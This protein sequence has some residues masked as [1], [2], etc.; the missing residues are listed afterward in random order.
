MFG[1]GKKEKKEKKNKTVRSDGL[2]MNSRLPYSLLDW[3]YSWDK[4]NYDKLNNQYKHDAIARRVVAKPA[5]D[6]TR[7][8][9]RLVIADDPDKQETYQ[10]ALDKLRL[11]DVLT[12]QLIYQ[13]LHGDGYINVGVKEIN[14]GSS[15]LRKPLIPENVKDVAFVHAFGQNHIEQYQYN[16]DPTSDNYKKE[17]SI[18]IRPT[19]AGYK[20]NEQ[21]MQVPNPVNS[22]PIILDKSRYFHITLDKFEDDATGT[23]II[24]RCS[25]QLKAMNIALESTGKMLREFTFKVINSDELANEN[26]EDFER[27]LRRLTQAMNTEAIA[28]LHKDDELAKVATPVNGYDTLLNFVWQELSAACNIPKSVLTGEQAGSLAGA[29]QDVVNY[30]DTV[31]S[32]QESLLKPEIEYIV[33]L[34]MYADDIGDGQEDPDSLDWHIEFNPLWSPDDKTQSETFNNNANAASTLVSS[35]IYDPDEAK[36]ILNGMSNNAIQG[37]QNVTKNDSSDKLTPEQVKQYLDD[38]KKATHGQKT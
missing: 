12:Q 29:S 15:D 35:A 32:M 5:E 7:N 17:Q 13:R 31:K 14:N 37:M 36:Q 28:V 1:I 3:Q 24:T 19:Q 18:T 23:S 20:T 9:W 8:G 21:G 4:Q 11:N 2:D 25:E 10:D 16:D 30:Y 38:M 22:K 27:D 6:A 34:L 26:D 33:R